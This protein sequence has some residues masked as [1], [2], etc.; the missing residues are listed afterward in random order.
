MA[1]EEKRVHARIQD[2]RIKIINNEHEFDPTH[3]PSAKTKA[4]PSEIASG[5]GDKQTYKSPES[6]HE[7]KGPRGRPRKNPLPVGDE[8]QPKAKAKA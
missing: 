3:R 6:E 1:N 5:S 4:G 7:P 2:E 8:A